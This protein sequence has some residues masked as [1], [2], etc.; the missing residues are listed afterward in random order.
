MSKDSIQNIVKSVND[1]DYVS[2]KAGFNTEISDKLRSLIN[3]RRE[4]IAKLI[5]SPNTDDDS[6]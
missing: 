5:F 2:A 3:K 6:N 1:G 4:E